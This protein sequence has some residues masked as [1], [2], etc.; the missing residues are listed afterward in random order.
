MG[1][2]VF[3]ATFKQQKNHKSSNNSADINARG[4][5]Y[6]TFYSCN[7]YKS[8]GSFCCQVQHGSQ[9]MFSSIHT[10]KNKKILI[11]QLTLMPGACTIKRFTAVISIN[12]LVAS[13][14]RWQ[15]GCKGM[16]SNFFTAKNHKIS[17]KFCSINI[18]CLPYKTFYRCN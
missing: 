11:T 14:A 3:L 9:G 12:Q 18:K 2:R 13:A 10:A 16:L 7:Q 17:N 1:P 4:L 8:A 5:H 6:K 15:H